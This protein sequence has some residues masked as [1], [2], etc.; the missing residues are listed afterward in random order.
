MKP[1]LLELLGNKEGPF[2][3]ALGISSGTRFEGVAP[4]PDLEVVNSTEV[5]VR[6]MVWQ[7]LDV[8]ARL[9]ERIDAEPLRICRLVAELEGGGEV[10]FERQ[11]LPLD[12]MK[13]QEVNITKCAACL[14][15]IP[16]GDA[17]ISDNIAY[18]QRCFER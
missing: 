11:I 15:N 1:V 12:E 13:I 14:G 2:E 16:E 9:P 7:V 17:I 6:R 3:F 4:Y 5:H 10:E 8:S 18:H